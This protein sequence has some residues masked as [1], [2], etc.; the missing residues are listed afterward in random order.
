MRRSRLLQTGLPC[1]WRQLERVEATAGRAEAVRAGGES[2]GLVLTAKLGV[3]ERR[4]PG[5]G[6]SHSGP[7]LDPCHGIWSPEHGQK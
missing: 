5:T 2:P 4:G 6:L 7:R 1:L 3:G